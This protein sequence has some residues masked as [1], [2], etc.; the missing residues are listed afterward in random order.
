MEKEFSKLFTQEIIQDVFNNYGEVN[1]L[2]LSEQCGATNTGLYLAFTA[3]RKW[4][5]ETWVTV[6]SALDALEI[7][8]DKIIIH[9]KVPERLKILT[10]GI[11]KKA[12]GEKRR[13]L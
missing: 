3:K 13:I 4:N 11:S 7:K 10:E 1:F 8:K 5:A 9:A 2:K 12:Y 6:L